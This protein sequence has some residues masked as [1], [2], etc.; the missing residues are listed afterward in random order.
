MKI[1]IMTF[2]NAQNYGAVLQAYALKKF[3]QKENPSY[4]VEIV[5]YKN[6]SIEQ[7]YQCFR[8]WSAFAHRGVRRLASFLLQFYYLFDRVALKRVFKEF[9]C[10]WLE[11]VNEGFDVY[12]CIMYGSD[13]IWNPSITGNDTSYFGKGFTGKKIAYAASDGGELVL[14][15][16]NISLL[17]DFHAIS[18]REK[19]LSHKLSQHLPEKSVETV[20]DPVFLLS[21]EEWLSFGS[22]PKERNYVLIYKIV[23]NKEIDTEAEAF[24]RKWG[25]QVIQI[26]YAK[27]IRKIFCCAQKFI[28]AITPNQFVGY[29]AHAD[30]VLTT[31]FHGTAFSI[32]LEKD[33]YTFQFVHRSGRVLD[34]LQEF[35]LSNRFVSKL[36]LYQNEKQKID[37]TEVARRK[38]GYRQRSADFLATSLQALDS[39]N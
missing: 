13:Q 39:T 17:Q 10:E 19:S 29:F 14:G 31:S 2:H 30:L 35:E 27:N 6:A 32:L 28:R 33:F 8:P 9:V 37:W 21:K 4:T 16:E 1:G 24:A 22:P 20:C 3:L 34:L 25:K 15:E 38:E 5:D 11:P 12:D 7:S 18:C 23:D 36:S 26:V